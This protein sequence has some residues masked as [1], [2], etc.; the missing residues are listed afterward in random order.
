MLRMN[1]NT[2]ISID[3]IFVILTIDA[4]VVLPFLLAEDGFRVR[5]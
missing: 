1:I 3:K 2:T 4:L 5:E